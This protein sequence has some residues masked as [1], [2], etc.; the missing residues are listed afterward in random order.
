[1]AFL[2][3]AGVTIPVA[4]NSVQ[5]SEE[6]IGDSGRTFDGTWRETIRN[7][8]WDFAGETP[9]ITRADASSVYDTLTSSSQPQTCAGDLISSSGGS[10]SCFTKVSRFDPHVSG[11]THAVSIRFELKQSS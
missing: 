10:L 4:A 3:V 5:R 6:E 8:V 11:S 2:T 9:L 1:M 7:R